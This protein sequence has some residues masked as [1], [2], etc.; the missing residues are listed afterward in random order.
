MMRFKLLGAAALAALALPAAAAASHISAAVAVA[1]D[2]DRIAGVDVQ[3]P[4]EYS[5][6][7]TIT[8]SPFEFAGGSVFLRQKFGRD[9]VQGS[10]SFSV[11]CDETTH[12]AIATV[13]PEL[14]PFHGGKALLDASVFLCTY[15]PLTGQQECGGANTSAVISIR[16]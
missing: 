8:P 5:C 3:V 7:P 2:G 12:V 15:D 4:I 14:H 16:G 11:I 1:G 10:G 6:G 13:R 9:I